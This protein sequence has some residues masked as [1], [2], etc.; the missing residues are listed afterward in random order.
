MRV[1]I[2]AFFAVL[3][4]GLLAGCAPVKEYAASRDA[5][6]LL[7][8]GSEALVQADDAG[9]GIYF[10][11]AA[12]LRP[13]GDLFARIGLTYHFQGH[14]REALPWLEKAFAADP[15]QPWPVQI[16][17]AAAHAASGD[18]AGGRR[19]MQGALPWMPDDPLVLNN[20]AYPMADAGLLLEEVVIV[21]K[22]A[23]KK[24][25]GEG[26]ILDSLGWAYF[27]QG[28]VEEA[29]RLLQ[30]AAR[31]SGDTEIRRHLT[32]ARKALALRKTER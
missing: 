23:T 12:A 26:I 27:R 31:L 20:T 3:L 2:V 16:A 8:A 13:S 10:R 21:L 6:R 19:I 30:E 32:E 15:R 11:R 29:V 25:P 9:A 4:C 28:R 7:A 1:P 5:E 14:F 24:A 22:K 17:L 18:S